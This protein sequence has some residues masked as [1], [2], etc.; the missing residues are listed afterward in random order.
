MLG[1]DYETPPFGCGEPVGWDTGYAGELKDFAAAVLDGSPLA[2]DP[3]EAI[4]DLR[5]MLAI[6]KA[7]KTGP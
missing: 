6:M 3:Q 4:E 2:A 7:A 1:N 5:L